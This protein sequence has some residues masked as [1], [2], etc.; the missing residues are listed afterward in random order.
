MQINELPQ[1][2]LTFKMNKPKLTRS[3]VFVLI[4]MLFVLVV[5]GALMFFIF[6]KYFIPKPIIN[7]KSNTLEVDNDVYENKWLYS[8]MQK[9]ANI[10]K[11][12]VTKK[13]PDAILT[14][15]EIYAKTDNV[16]EISFPYE[17]LRSF[18]D[19]NY[20]FNFI[21]SQ[22][23][24]AAVAIMKT[25]MSENEVIKIFEMPLEIKSDEIILDNVSVSYKKAWQ[26]LDENGGYEFKIQNSDIEQ[27]GPFLSNKK[28]ELVWTC[29]YIGSGNNRKKSY[30]LE[31][32]AL[33]SEIQSINKK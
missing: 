9:K 11:K 29:G 17:S 12:E 25:D 20:F 33:N 14:K 7:E 27:I 28:D 4:L 30:T 6:Q 8:D 2:F 13:F 3:S 22:K 32:D 5:F 10:A 16:D 19:N 15:V 18:K 26:I 31:I 1:N 23:N 24:K 21:S